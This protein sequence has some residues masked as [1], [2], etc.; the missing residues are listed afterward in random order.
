MTSKRIALRDKHYLIRKEGKYKPKTIIRIV[1][2][3]EKTEPIYFRSLIRKLRITTT[4]VIVT[5]S[6]YG[7]DPLS[8]VNFALD[9]RE[10]NKQDNRLS[11]EPKYDY[12]FCV[13][14]KDDHTN[15]FDAF[16]KGID[17]NLFIIRSVPCF[18]IWLLLH[19]FYSAKP[20]DN[21]E[22]LYRALR[23]HIPSYEKGM[24]T[25]EYVWDKHVDAMKNADMLYIEQ[26]K[27]YDLTREHPNPLTEIHQIISI[28]IQP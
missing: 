2:E 17:N 27:L 10:R 24:D 9:V 8:V 13:F 22:E 21:R 1:T 28:I 12:I 26:S 5:P 7:S 25:L 18:E 4:K 19:Y 15:Y 11:G 3:G 20:Y 23:S 14:D 6:E 16:K